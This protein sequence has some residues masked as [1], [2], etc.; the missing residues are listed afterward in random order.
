MTII[1]WQARNNSGECHIG[2]FEIDNI[3]FQ[4]LAQYSYK[5]SDQERKSF[6]CHWQEVLQHPIK[7]INPEGK[8]V[9]KY[10]LH[11]PFTSL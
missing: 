1:K 8:V 9:P 7:E 11:V 6:Q 5:C 10:L 3:F 2:W 4:D